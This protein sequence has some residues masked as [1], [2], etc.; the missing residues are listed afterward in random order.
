MATAAA[1]P[2]VT[3]EDVRQVV[4]KGQDVGQVSQWTLM[5]WRF[6]Q[7]RLSVAGLV[8]LLL[9]YVIAAIA[10]FLE[11][12]DYQE[13]DT[14]YQW[15]APTRLSLVDGRL[16]A[17]GLKQTLNEANFTWVYTA[18]CSKFYPLQFFVRGHKYSLFGVFPTDVHLFGLG[19]AA[20]A[21]VPS[22]ALGQAA[23]RPPKLYLLGADA[24][25]RDLFSRLLEGSRISLTI[26]L[27]A[28]AI[29][30]ILGSVLGTASGYMGGSVDNLVQ[31]FIEL[32]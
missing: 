1:A 13:I 22:A 9:M 24:S 7:N 31:R 23:E 12:Y 11:P 3:I 16:G 21:A 27:L 14:N 10:P 25:G 17:C 29:V 20:A 5:R 6:M 2:G 30:L 15:A 28:A 4:E 8:I 26:G 18:D 19:Q 32:L